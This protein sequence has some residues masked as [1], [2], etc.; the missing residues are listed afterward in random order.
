MSKRSIEDM[1]AMRALAA[2]RALD[3]LADQEEGDFAREDA[4]RKVRDAYE[5]YALDGVLDE[6]EVDR[7]VASLEAL[8]IDGSEIHT[9]FEETASKNGGKV[10]ISDNARLESLIA[11]TFDNALNDR[12]SSIQAI[13][14]KVQ[15]AMSEYTESYESAAGVKK[16]LNDT[17]LNVIRNIA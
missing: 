17:Y 7:L 12:Q 4:I 14:L 10:D 5:A 1:F 9:L 8:G 3:Q 13:G 2:E 6:R 15:M 16:L 11:R